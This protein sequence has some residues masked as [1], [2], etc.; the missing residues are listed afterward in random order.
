MSPTVQF[1]N[2][3]LVRVASEGGFILLAAWMLMKLVGQPVRKL[4]VGIWGALAALIIAVGCT[5]SPWLPLRLLTAR[6]TG[7]HMPSIQPALIPGRP[8]A[9]PLTV[10]GPSVGSE[11]T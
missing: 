2:S 6:D 9:Q 7:P 10:V 3:W 8:G 11:P 5:L 4:Q 1:L